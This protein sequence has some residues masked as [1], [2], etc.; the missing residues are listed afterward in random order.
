M[1]FFH[2]FFF[3]YF[4]SNKL[5]HQQNY[6]IQWRIYQRFELH[7]HRQH[8]HRRY[9]LHRRQWLDHNQHR[10]HHRLCHRVAV[11]QFIACK[12]QK[13]TQS[14]HHCQMVRQISWIVHQ[15][16]NHNSNSRSRSSSNNRLEIVVQPLLQKRKS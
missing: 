7:H 4:K 9:R 2:S 14:Y 12:R 10:Q 15:I 1:F 3:R 8:H 16:K 11:I 6:I 5:A 13:S